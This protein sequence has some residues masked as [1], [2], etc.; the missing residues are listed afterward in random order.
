MS[1]AGVHLNPQISVAVPRG[2]TCGRDEDHD[3][4]KREG[5]AMVSASVRRAHRIL[6]HFEE[7]KMRHLKARANI[8]ISVISARDP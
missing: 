2:G 8:S 3:A 5:S 6:S 7:S 4:F 1:A